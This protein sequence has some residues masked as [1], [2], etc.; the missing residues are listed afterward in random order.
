MNS[1]T[2]VHLETVTAE[3]TFAALLESS[4]FGLAAALPRCNV[5]RDPGLT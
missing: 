1:D 4:N 3:Q 5:I 2:K